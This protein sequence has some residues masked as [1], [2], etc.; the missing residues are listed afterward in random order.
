MCVWGGG[1]VVDESNYRQSTETGR[2]EAAGA[3]EEMGC[4]LPGDPYQGN[5]GILK[6]SLVV[7]AQL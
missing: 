2:I 4:R 7:T 5:K 1:L 6:L 3:R